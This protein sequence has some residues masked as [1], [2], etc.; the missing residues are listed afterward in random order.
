[1]RLCYI[2]YL[3]AICTITILLNARSVSAADS[4]IVIRTQPE[5]V[6]LERNGQSQ[7]FAFAFGVSNHSDQAV[8]LVELRMMDYDE[9]GTLLNSSKVDSNGGR[10]SIEVLGPRQLDA[11]EGLAVFNPFDQL[12]TARPVATLRY[13][14]DFAGEKEMPIRDYRGGRASEA[15]FL[16]VLGGLDYDGDSSPETPGFY[17][18]H[19][20]IDLNDEFTRDVMKTHAPRQNCLRCINFSLATRSQLHLELMRHRSK[21]VFNRRGAR[22]RTMLGTAPKRSNL[23]IFPDDSPRLLPGTGPFT[24]RGANNHRT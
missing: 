7:Y 18:H 21:S 3:A 9:Q 6:Y 1:M 22:S 24:W 20:R 13:E 19:S 16:N 12:S 23:C 14:F 10:P 17:S 2:K 15:G 4:G 11:H 5:K 8:K